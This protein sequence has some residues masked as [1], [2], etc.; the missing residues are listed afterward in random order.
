MF[1]K[2][3]SACDPKT[4][5]VTPVAG[6]KNIIGV[7]TQ[8][9]SEDFADYLLSEEDL[10][11]GDIDPTGKGIEQL[12]WRYMTQAGN[13]VFSIGYYYDH[14]CIGYQINEVYSY[15]ELAFEEYMKDTR[16]GP[17]GIYGNSIGLVK[18]EN[19][20]FMVIL[21]PLMLRVLLLSKSLVL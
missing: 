9:S 13:T 5:E 11:S 15:P 6:E 21:L 10:M 2:I 17:L 3:L 14:N 16:L 20:A 12:G 7:Q 1:W 4:E 18:R 8:G 19:G